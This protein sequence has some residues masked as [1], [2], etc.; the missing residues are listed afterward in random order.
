MCIVNVRV[1]VLWLQG[2]LRPRCL[3]IKAVSGAS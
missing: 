3:D 1:R 2:Y